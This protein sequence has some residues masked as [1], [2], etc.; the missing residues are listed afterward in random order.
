MVLLALA[1]SSYWQWRISLLSADRRPARGVCTAEASRGE[2]ARD[3]VRRRTE[4]AMA[5][6]EEARPAV[7]RR[8]IVWRSRTRLDKM[9]TDMQWV[10]LLDRRGI[11]GR[12]TAA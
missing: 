8:Y 11:I 5:A 1:P 4:A 10:G 9:L 2:T 12:G 7:V 6:V 3:D